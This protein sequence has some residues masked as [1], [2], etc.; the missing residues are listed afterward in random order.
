MLR[1][2]APPSKN[3]S[4]RRV[5]LPFCACENTGLYNY[6]YTLAVQLIK[7][8]KGRDGTRQGCSRHQQ[9][10]F[11]VQL[12]AV[13]SREQSL[14]CN[15]FFYVRTTSYHICAIMQQKISYARIRM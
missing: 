9:E 15:C 3:L 5:V 12:L 13:W 14:R 8:N 4:G 7:Y 11:H 1:G 10:Q 6:S 2:N